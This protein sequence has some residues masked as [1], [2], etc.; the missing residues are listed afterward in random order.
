MK[1][2]EKELASLCENVKQVAIEAGSFI[3]RESKDF[4]LSKVE[5]KGFNDMVS[6]VDKEA[7][8]IIVAG[9]ENLLPGAGFITEEGTASQEEAYNWIIDPLDGTTNFIHGLPVYSVSIALAKGKHPIMGVVYEINREEC[10]YAWENGGAY[11][12]EK[13]IQVSKSKNLSTSLIS[14]GFPYSNF[15]KMG[16]YFNIMGDIM[17]KSHGLR[18]FGSAAVDLA[19]TACGRFEGYFEYNLNSY[20]IAAGA[21]IVKEA[22]GFVGEFDGGDD[23]LFGR[24]IVA[25]C[26]VYPELLTIIKKY[27]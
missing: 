27:W 4:D 20:D 26:N 3:S 19:Y 2:E 11:C 6:Y 7:E 16:S 10:F 1:I 13:P 5:M 17:Q 23:Y 15:D 25:G 14:T 21:I 18:R 24:S 8:K 22:G 9:L 12:N